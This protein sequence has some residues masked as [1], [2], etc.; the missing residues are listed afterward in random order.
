MQILSY[1]S[2]SCF[3]QLTC[4]G[5]RPRPGVKAYE[6]WDCAPTP[7]ARIETLSGTPCSLNFPNLCDN[8]VKTLVSE[9]RKC[10]QL[11]REFLPPTPNPGWA[12]APK[13]IILF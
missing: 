1:Y 2:I 6:K 5:R 3:R 4:S 8:F 7:Y 12:P 9:I 13:P 11:Q 10:H